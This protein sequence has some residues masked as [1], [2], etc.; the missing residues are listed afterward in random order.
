MLTYI[1]NE[2]KTFEER[3]AEAITQI[4]LYTDEWTNFN[5]SDPGITI[6]ETLTG[7]ETLQQDRLLETSQRVR[8]NLLK[9]V[10]FKLKKGRGARLWR[11]R[12]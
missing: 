4:P 1:S 2:G 3:F 8:I 10:G 7:F 5:P 9:M 6:L 12:M 11:R